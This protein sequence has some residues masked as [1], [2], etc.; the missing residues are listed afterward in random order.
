MSKGRVAIWHPGKCP[1]GPVSNVS[2]SAFI[3]LLFIYSPSTTLAVGRTGAYPGYPVAEFTLKKSAAHLT[4]S[5]EYQTF[6]QLLKYRHWLVCLFD[7]Q[8]VAFGWLANWLRPLTLSIWSMQVLLSHQHSRWLICEGVDWVW[9]NWLFRFLLILLVTQLCGIAS[10]KSP[11][12]WTSRLTA[13]V[14]AL[15]W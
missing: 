9:V 7:S 8:H 14:I 12:L 5:T 15:C 3:F 2:C 6:W 1:A 13:W 11:R 10:L 4:V